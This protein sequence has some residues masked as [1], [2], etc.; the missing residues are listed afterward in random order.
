MNGR[1]GRPE[2]EAARLAGRDRLV[3]GEDSAYSSAL[4]WGKR[5]PDRA[6]AAQNRVVNAVEGMASWRLLW[7]GDAKGG[8]V[9]G[10]CGGVMQM[11]PKQGSCLI[12]PP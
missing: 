7:G 9:T 4:P 1:K 12:H 3:D 2:G 8:H 5:S 10:F 6:T 11:E